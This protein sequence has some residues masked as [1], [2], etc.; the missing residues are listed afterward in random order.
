MA[1]LNLADRSDLMGVQVLRKPR[2]KWR[3][4]STTLKLLEDRYARDE[5]DREE[6]EQRKRY[7]RCT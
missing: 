2:L 7:L 5:S 3:K 1:I 4:T 6:F